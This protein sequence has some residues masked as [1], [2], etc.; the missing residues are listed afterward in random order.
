MHFVQ[1]VGA[2]IQLV[3][4]YRVTTTIFLQM[5]VRCL[6]EGTL[7]SNVYQVAV[8]ASHG[9]EAGGSIEHQTVWMPQ[10]LGEPSAIG[11]ALSHGDS[12]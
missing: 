8:S 9:A 1:L 6:E 4:L 12:W 3:G 5:A 7:F 2:T 11:Q 10:I